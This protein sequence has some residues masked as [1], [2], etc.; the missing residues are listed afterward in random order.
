MT[1]IRALCIGGTW[2][3]HYKMFDVSRN[4]MRSVRVEAYLTKTPCD[5]ETVAAPSELETYELQFVRHA[6][7]G[8]DWFAIA[9]GNTM[10]WALNQLI[11]AYRLKTGGAT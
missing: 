1:K 5:Y 7:G 3:G 4:A 6:G 11:H 10:E 8:E 9:D 2:A